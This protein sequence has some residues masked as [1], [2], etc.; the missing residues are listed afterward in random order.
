[1]TLIA[2]DVY[3]LANFEFRVMP[4]WRI[5]KA[6]FLSVFEVLT[7]G[8]N[9][10]IS[11]R[12]QAI[13]SARFASARQAP[14]RKRSKSKASKRPLAAKWIPSTQR[15]TPR[16]RC[17]Y[18]GEREIGVS[19]G[20]LKSRYGITNK[21]NASIEDLKDMRGEHLIIW[22]RHLGIYPYWKM[23]IYE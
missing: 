11:T 18:K 16:V 19:G 2:S 8:T 12:R 6:L 15:S 3:E 5:T 17:N 14:K 20:I 1:M 22:I 9:S 4:Q 23:K 10:S 21:K 13:T 7:R